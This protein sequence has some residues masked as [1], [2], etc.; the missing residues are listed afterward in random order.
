MT[1]PNEVGR[2]RQNESIAGLN[3]RDAASIEDSRGKFRQ[4]SKVMHRRSKLARYTYDFQ[5]QI[6]TSLAASGFSLEQFLSRGV[7]FLTEFWSRV[8]SLHMD[9]E[10]TLYRDRQWSREIQP[11]D[12]V[13][14]SHLVLGVPYCSVIVVDKFWAR[15]LGETGLAKSYGTSVY[16]NLTGLNAV[17]AT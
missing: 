8:P 5:D 10:L 13:D 2:N 9:C 14:L 1:F 3:Q 15:A 6:T 7:A 12:F 16:D 17:I 11:N 4:V